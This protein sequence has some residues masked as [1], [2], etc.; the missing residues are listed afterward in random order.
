MKA[1]HSL[2]CRPLH[3]NWLYRFENAFTWTLISS[4]YN[5]Q[6]NGTFSIY[7]SEYL[8]IWKLLPKLKTTRFQ[9]Y[10]YK[11]HSFQKNI[12]DCLRNLLL[13]NWLIH[14]HWRF[15]IYQLR[16]IRTMQFSIVN[17]GFEQWR[18]IDGISFT[19]HIPFV[20]VCVLISYREQKSSESKFKKIVGNKNDLSRHTR[21]KC[22]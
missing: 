15:I 6:N 20:I 22:D 16:E 7:A 12:F 17:Q 2:H 9:W 19:E 18:D 14:H 4:T 10:S 1:M 3:N 11:W 5:S 8:S 13:Q 21:Q